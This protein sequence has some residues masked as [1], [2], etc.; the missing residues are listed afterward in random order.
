MSFWIATGLLAVLLAGSIGLLGIRGH[1]EWPW[2]EVLEGFS[3]H[4]L[5]I[6][7]ISCHLGPVL[8]TLKHW[9]KLMDEVRGAYEDLVD[10]VASRGALEF[11]SSWD[12]DPFRECFCYDSKIVLSIPHG[13]DVF[14]A[15]FGSR[16]WTI[17]HCSR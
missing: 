2:V 15:L 14:Y 13:R 4:Y 8:I 7:Q 12:I 16:R 11:R 1:W 6:R 3:K 10:K 9:M 17:Q 5:G